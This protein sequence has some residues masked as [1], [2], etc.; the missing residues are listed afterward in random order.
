MFCENRQR[1]STKLKRKK[2]H[3]VY[4]LKLTNIPQ[5][6]DV[7]KS[8]QTK[9][10]NSQLI[11]Y[12]LKI[13]ADHQDHQPPPKIKAI[14]YLQTF[15]CCFAEIQAISWFALQKL[16]QFLGLLCKNTCNFL[17]CFAEIQAICWLA[18]QKY[19]QFLGSLCRNISN[20]LFSF[21]RIQAISWFALQKYKQFVGLH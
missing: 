11:A 3:T 15:Y 4:Y 18:L 5:I 1:N 14:H 2:I 10:T 8:A 13:C 20:F 16:K 21:A 19:R 6:G 17:V 12:L 7:V 9:T